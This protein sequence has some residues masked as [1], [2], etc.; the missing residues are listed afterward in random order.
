MYVYRIAGLP[1]RQY[2]HDADDILRGTCWCTRKITRYIAEPNSEHSQP[3]RYTDTVIIIIGKD[4]DTETSE[5]SGA[6]MDGS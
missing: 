6:A 1:K 2:Y 5:V 3:L 4:D